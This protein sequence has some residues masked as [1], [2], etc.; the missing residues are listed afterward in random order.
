MSPLAVCS[1][2]FL[3]VKPEVSGNVPATDRTE[4]RARAGTRARARATESERKSKSKS[5]SKGSKSQ[6]DKTSD[7]ERER[8]VEEVAKRRG[9]C[10]VASTPYPAL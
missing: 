3:Y 8:P 2:P 7:R 6:S 4:G 5:K 10:R 9:C 1:V